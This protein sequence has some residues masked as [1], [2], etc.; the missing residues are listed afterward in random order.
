MWASAAESDG[1]F[2]EVA[3]VVLFSV[4]S[5]TR[6]LRRC[7][8]AR[9][10]TVPARELPLWMARVLSRFAPALRSIRPQLGHDFGAAGGKAERLLGWAQRHIEDTIADTGES[11]LS[12]GVR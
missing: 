10:S 9:A 1:W 11:I 5:R 8:G 12:S 2:S 6:I 4:S 3:C 7:L